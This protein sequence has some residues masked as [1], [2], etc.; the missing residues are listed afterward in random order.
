M[1]YFYGLT[2]DQLSG[3]TI[4]QFSAY[5]SEIKNIMLIFNGKPPIKTPAEINTIANQYGIMG[6][7]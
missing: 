1:S 2:I 3:M 6:P 7:R 4:Y 5:L